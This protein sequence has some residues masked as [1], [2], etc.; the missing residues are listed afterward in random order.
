MMPVENLSVFTLNLKE[1][2]ARVP[3]EMVTAIQ[4]KIALTALASIVYRTPVDTGRARGS[5]QCGVGKIPVSQS[6]AIDKDGRATITAGEVVID[7]L[8]PFDVLYIASNL[9]YIRWLEDGGLKGLDDG[10]LARKR[11]RA[12][13]DAIHR[14]KASHLAGDEGAL[15]IDQA[16]MTLQ[17]PQG[18]VRITYEELKAKLG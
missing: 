17:S 9:S 18:M 14:Q 15:I 10:E 6:K 8:P 4:K 11:R 7:S 12:R 13:R 5:W 2:A 3:A 16:G 1:I